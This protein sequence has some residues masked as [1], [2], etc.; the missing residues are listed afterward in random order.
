MHR[1]RLRSRV[2][3]VIAAVHLVVMVG[4]GCV[5]LLNA[6]TAVAREIVAA[7][8]SAAILIRDTVA[9]RTADPAT[10]L[11]DLRGAILR[12]R[13]VRI[14][15]LPSDEG[16]AVPLFSPEGQGSGDK[17][18]PGWF[19][20]WV[21]PD[22]GP[23]TVPV[24]GR[25]GVP[26]G[27]I[28]IAASAGDEA[29]EVWEDVAALF[30]VWSLATLALLLLSGMLVR[31]ALDPLRQLETVLM[32]LQS[33]DY[34]SRAAA[35]NT[36]DLRPIGDRID[37]LA[38]S[39]QHSEADRK[40]L[41][42][43]LLALR[44]DER[45]TLARDLHD[46]MGPC[47]FG[48]SVMAEGLGADPASAP[49]R[50]A[51]IERLVTDMR[52]INRRVLDTLRPSS[53]GQLPLPDV[54]TDLVGDHA[55]AHPNVRFDLVCPTPLPRTGDMADAT[56]YRVLQEALTNALRH[57]QPSHIRITLTATQTGDLRLSVE[58]D[59]HGPRAGWAEGRGLMGMR[60]R[61]DALDGTLRLDRS[62]TLGG[63]RLAVTLPVGSPAGP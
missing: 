20:G 62:E 8:D 42:A 51:G 21:A 48:L 34:G 60:E 54:V 37:R 29:A 27:V 10:V 1:I 46:E 18:V 12:P 22:I 26:R 43:K 45:R 32:R 28:E 63:A 24:A 3:L 6:R 52:R 50:A 25:D 13:H 57:S 16:P 9:H 15:Y 14:R 58:D 31:R 33:G 40:A 5:L 49:E 44:E 30:L 39:L 36:P 19:L 23:V 53:I 41:S 17:V 38:A 11:Q 55:D 7:Q 61:I 2:L 59:G 47:L 4:A 35:I 56:L